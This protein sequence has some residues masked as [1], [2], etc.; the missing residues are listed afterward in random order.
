MSIQ[1]DFTNTKIAFEHYEKSQLRKTYAI[2]GL[3][4][5][6]WLV[7]IGTFFIKTGL[8]V[9][10]PIKSIIK[11]TIFNHF[12]GG[13]SI[14]D[15]EKTINHLYKYNIGTILDYSVEGE[16]TEKVF[17]ET[18]KE[19]LKT[20]EYSSLNR[21]K[22]PF[23]VFKVSGLTQ[24]SL[25]EKIGKS[26][27]KLNK[28][29]VKSYN[30]LKTRIEELAST[31]AKLKVKLFF[32]AEETWIQDAIDELV[33]EMMAKYNVNGEA[34]IYNTYQMYRKKAFS[35]L[36]SHFSEAEQKGFI[37]GAKLVR[38]AYMEKERKRAEEESYEDPINESKD[39]SD[40]EFNNALTFAI[41]NI[42]KFNICLGTHNEESSK[43]CVELMI[44]NGIAINDSRVYFAQLMGMSDNIS[45]N[46]SK[47]G[48]NVAKYVPYG[49]VEAVMPYLFRRAEENTAMAGQSS[50]EFLLIE[51]ELQRRKKA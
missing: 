35:I 31:A 13:E 28:E 26:K 23:S 29:E 1:V 4:N 24:N 49:P 2:F 14:K 16:N 30:L 43:L 46:L 42:E 22:I 12:C 15:C 51:K 40:K 34:F 18:Q 45:F 44:K 5:K 7:K 3:M 21:D 11:S 17:I 20:I 9:G 41:E 8:D 25:L 47:A 50:R 33:L 38:G 36:E 39:K 27:S 37:V 6:N 19:I 48:F 32:D 10:L